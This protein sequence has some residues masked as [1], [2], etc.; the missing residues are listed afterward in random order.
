[1]PL[2]GCEKPWTKP[3]VSP[4]PTWADAATGTRAKTATQNPRK[5]RIIFVRLLSSD[6]VARCTPRADRLQPSS[7][8]N[9]NCIRLLDRTAGRTIGDIRARKFKR[10]PAVVAAGGVEFRR[11]VRESEQVSFKK[12]IEAKPGGV[13]LCLGLFEP[14]LRD[15]HVGKTPP[16]LRIAA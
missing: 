14:V 7:A 11:M 8:F 9:C 10:P 16:D 15:Q 13:E 4:T 6:A 3:W 2:S 1:M 12:F 5:D